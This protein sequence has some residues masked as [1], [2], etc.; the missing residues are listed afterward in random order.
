MV[1]QPSLSSQNWEKSGKLSNVV[2]EFP[3]NSM[4][5][6]L[7][8]PLLKT[9]GCGLFTMHSSIIFHN[10]MEGRIFGVMFDRERKSG[11]DRQRQTEHQR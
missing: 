1:K 2:P 7:L 3:L 9:S 5:F 8:L 4:N 6:M 11:K 10:I